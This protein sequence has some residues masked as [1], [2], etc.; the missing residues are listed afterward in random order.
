MYRDTGHNP[1]HEPDFKHRR[2]QGDDIEREICNR[3]GFIHYINP[4]VVVGARVLTAD[5]RILLCRRSIEPQSGLW[6]LPAG[7]MELGESMEEGA[8]RE[9]W[10]EAR[11]RIT[12]GPLLRHFSIKHISQVQMF[13]EA[14]LDNPDSIAPGPESLETALFEKDTVPWRELAFPTVQIILK[15]WAEAD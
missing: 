6:T 11:A 4:K 2:P 14:T 8:A 10:E 7:F 1:P 9:A 3:C 13:F 15:E 5:D 12:V